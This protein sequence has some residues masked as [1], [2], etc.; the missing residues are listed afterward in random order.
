MKIT[1][2]WILP[3]GFYSA[4]PTEVAVIASSADIAE[5]VTDTDWL[6]K[7]LDRENLVSKFNSQKEPSQF[8]YDRVMPDACVG[9]L[10]IDFLESVALS[11]LSWAILKPVGTAAQTVT[12]FTYRVRR[13]GA[14]LAEV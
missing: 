1:R 3:F 12:A 8:K 9:D 4:S 5:V 2:D 13:E 14:L 11:Q 6:H 10:V 7:A